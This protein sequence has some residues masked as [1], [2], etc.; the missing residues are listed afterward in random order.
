MYSGEAG[1]MGQIVEMVS[2]L[3]YSR[4]EMD[5]AED[6]G[7]G[8]QPGSCLS[9]LPDEKRHKAQ[10]QQDRYQSVHVGA[11]LNRRGISINLIP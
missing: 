11:S 2:P 1:I 3:V 10:S 9:P 5:R 8:H 4:T 7:K 6:N